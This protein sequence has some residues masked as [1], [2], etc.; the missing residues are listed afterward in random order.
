M[1]GT[2]KN[3]TKEQNITNQTRQPSAS[4]LS[5]NGKD[6]PST[7]SY[8][9]ENVAD[10]NYSKLSWI[11]HILLHFVHTKSILTFDRLIKDEMENWTKTVLIGLA[12]E[13]NICTKERMNI[14]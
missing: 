6:Q 5:K 12:L 9:V 11:I 2:H 14:L 8:T 13:C 3:E 1:I 7:Y 4:Q 10:K